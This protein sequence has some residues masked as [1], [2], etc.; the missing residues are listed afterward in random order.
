MALDE[1]LQL[2]VCLL[3]MGAAMVFNNADLF[4]P[5]VPAL[6]RLPS[7]ALVVFFVLLVDFAIIAIRI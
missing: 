7:L 1:E 3:L 6:A 4:F 5:L 2:F